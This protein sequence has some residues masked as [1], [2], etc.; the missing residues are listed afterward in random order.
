MNFVEEIQKNNAD[1]VILINGHLKK[2]IINFVISRKYRL[3]W[4]T[5]EILD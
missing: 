3:K 2:N 4:T 1:F 5:I